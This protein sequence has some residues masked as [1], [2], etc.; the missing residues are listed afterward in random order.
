MTVP[1]PIHDVF[2]TL[3]QRLRTPPPVIVATGF[4]ETVYVWLTAIADPSATA[5]IFGDWITVGE[6]RNIAAHY[7]ATKGLVAKPLEIDAAKQLRERLAAIG[8]SVELVRPDEAEELLQA[9]G[10]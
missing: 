8:T 1:D 2:Q 6:L 3:G 7:R 5:G 9:H 10:G 4:E